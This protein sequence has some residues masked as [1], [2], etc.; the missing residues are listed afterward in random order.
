[1]ATSEDRPWPHART[2]TWPLT[3]GDPAGAARNQHEFDLPQ[4]CNDATDVVEDEIALG[5]L[6]VAS[7]WL[8]E[9]RESKPEGIGRLVERS[10]QHRRLIDDSAKPLKA[11]RHE[12][13]D[14]GSR[15]GWRSELRSAAPSFGGCRVRLQF[16]SCC[17]R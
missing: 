13:Q 3:H 4:P 11:I 16:S 1:M 2:L 17:T 15:L 12:L 9:N 7:P 8:R 10:R 6:G 5:L 14:A